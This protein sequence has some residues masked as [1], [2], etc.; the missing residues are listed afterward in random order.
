ME[1]MPDLPHSHNDTD[2]QRHILDAMPSEEAI[3][4]VSEALRQLGDP[5]RL[6]IFWLLCHTEECVADIAA[7][8]GMSSPAVSHHLRLLKSAELV[9]SRRAGKEMLYRAAD[10]ELA[11]ELHHIIERI[12]EISCPA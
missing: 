3:E 4:V 10:T 7:C 2:T 6:R 9:V 12:A 8:V 5:S 11:G 1:R